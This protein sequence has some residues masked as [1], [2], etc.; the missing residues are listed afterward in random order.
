MSQAAAANRFHLLL[1]YLPLVNFNP[2]GFNHKRVNSHSVSRFVLEIEELIR[3][4]ER[5][6]FYIF[7]PVFHS[8]YEEIKQMSAVISQ[9]MFQS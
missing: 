3:V 6:I 7:D 8:E 5:L 4:Q 2:S 1:A 9:G